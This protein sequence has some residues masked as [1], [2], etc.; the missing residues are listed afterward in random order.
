MYNTPFCILLVYHKNRTLSIFY[1]YLLQN[2]VVGWIW[3]WNLE[4]F[5]TTSRL[6]PQRYRIWVTLFNH[7]P[8]IQR[9]SQRKQQ[10]SE[11]DCNRRPVQ[12]M[13]ISSTPRF[14]MLLS[15]PAQNFALS[16]S[17]THIPR[18]SFFPS[19]LMPIAMYTAFFTMWTRFHFTLYILAIRLTL[20]SAKP[21]V[22]FHHQ[23]TPHSGKTTVTS[24]ANDLH[25]LILIKETWCPLGPPPFENR[26]TQLNCLKGIENFWTI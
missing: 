26:C 10:T 4:V 23:V 24:A 14:L 16:F 19:I 18:T 15:T 1:S 11:D 9:C 21:V 17:P 13:R 25:L 7:T 3:G 8:D 22:G 12:A 2:I 6:R 20:L 5:C